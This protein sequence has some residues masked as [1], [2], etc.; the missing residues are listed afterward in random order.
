MLFLCRHRN[1][2]YYVG[3]FAAG[4]EKWNSLKITL[5]SVARNCRMKRRPVAAEHQKLTG[6]VTEISGM[7]EF[8]GALGS[9]RECLQM[10]DLRPNA[11][12]AYRGR[13][14]NSCCEVGGGRSPERP[15]HQPSFNAKFLRK[16]PNWLCLFLLENF[17]V[18]FSSQKK[19]LQSTAD[20]ECRWQQYVIASRLGCDFFVAW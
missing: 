9:C 4:K 20:V 3:T 6:G 1:G 19:V 2:R 16:F 14:L 17:A 15:A 12:K 11:T 7:L 8:G 18:S 13:S 10:A 5:L